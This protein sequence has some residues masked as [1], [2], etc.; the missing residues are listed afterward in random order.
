M[1]DISPSRSLCGNKTGTKPSAQAGLESL[2]ENCRTGAFTAVAVYLNH[3]G[4]PMGARFIHDKSGLPTDLLYFPSVYQASIYFKTLAGD[5]KGVPHVLEHLVL[6]KGGKGKYLNTLMDMSLGEAT[7]ATYS[8]LTS[9]QF[10]TAGGGEDFYGLLEK[11]LDALLNPDFTDDEIRREVYNPDA[12]E[13]PGGGFSLEE[14]GSVYNEMVSSMEKPSFNNWCQLISMVYGERHPLAVNHGGLPSAMRSL[15]PAEI[16]SFHSAN[17]RLGAN[18]LLLAV[19][20]TGTDYTGFLERLDAIINRVQPSLPDVSYAGIPAFK[21]APAGDVSIGTFPSDDVNS[22]GEVFMAWRPVTGLSEGES[23]TLETLLDIFGGGQTSYLYR[24]LVDGTARRK[25]FGISSVSAFFDGPP[26]SMAGLVM[27]GLSPSGIRRK[28][29]IALRA[30]VQERLKWLVSLQ[31]GSAGLKETFEK[32]RS[33]LSSRRRSNLKFM[34]SPPHFGMRSGSIAW[35]RHLDWLCSFPGFKK[36]LPQEETFG[37]L[38]EKLDCGKNIWREI[39]LKTGLASGLYIS[40]VKPDKALLAGQ[41]KGKKQRLAAVLEEI[42]LKYEAA[43]EQAALSRKSVESRK[44]TQALDR[45]DAANPRP[46]FIKEPPLTLDDKIRFSRRS[47]PGTGRVTLNDAGDSPFLD[48]GVFFDISRVPARDLELMPLLVP[49]LTEIGVLTASG[50]ELDY[51]NMVERWQSEIYSLSSGV[52]SNAERGR[53]ELYLMATASD[54]SETAK[55]VEWLKNCLNRRLLS[56]SSRSR[57]ID[58]AKRNIQSLRTMT[59][60]REEYWVGEAAA[61]WQYQHEAAWMAVRSPFTRLQSLWRVRWMLEDPSSS[62]LTR[63]KATLCSIAKT[64]GTSSRR[65]VKK[66]TKGLTDE[67]AEGFLWELD[68]MPEETW[69]VDAAELARITL[70]CLKTDSAKT[71]GRLKNLLDAVLARPGIRVLMTGNA[72]AMQ[73]AC[74]LMIPVLKS[75][76]RKPSSGAVAAGK[77]AVVLDRINGRY[78]FIAGKSGPEKPVHAALVNNGTKSGVFLISAKS[79]TY[80]DVSEKSIIDFLASKVLAGGGSHGLFMKTWEAGLAYSNGL[81][82][83]EVRGRLSY[84]AERCPDPART[85]MF[86][87]GVVSSCGLKDF[88]YPQYALANSFSDYRGADDYSSRGHAMAADLEDGIT[89]EAVKVFKK[90]LIRA[91]KNPV[92]GA[93]ISARVKPVLGRVIAGLGMKISSGRQTCAFVTGPEYLLKKYEDYLRKE[94]ETDSLVRL[95]PRD[96]WLPWQE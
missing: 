54:M 92:T 51:S 52:E 27:S 62:N 46:G 94:G 12:L 14:T 1:P 2:K 84:Y 37:T 95:Y 16:R 78:Q 91:A 24:D 59:Q 42:R 86:A 33:V 83:N 65:T 57:I 13:I 67:M 29:L 30:A 74:D 82:S 45:R 90:A 39:I 58:I 61:A 93:K 6:G 8:D 96:F 10:N 47:L 73:S 87:A 76:P 31:P 68:H 88:F 5:C 81:S 38:L 43:D 25:D 19:L 50:E 28:K 22:P 11:F 26:S 48:I 23:L 21:P 70:A 41:R 3:L 34:D 17:Y 7:A 49:A 80:R 18:A 32:A 35:H 71:I 15:T 85:M 4:R 75:L 40:A 55:A 66:L 72:P 56:V 64:A 53:L 63:L 69:R 60:R 20:P 89:P 9:Y 36:S 44:I 77:A 79:L